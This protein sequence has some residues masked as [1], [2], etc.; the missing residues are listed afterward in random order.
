MWLEVVVEVAEESAGEEGEEAGGYVV[1]H[2]AGAGGEGFE[3]TDGPGFP[4]V[5]ETE[6]EEVER[7]VMPVGRGED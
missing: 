2:D 4:D 7:G 6:E 3:A 1:E 5:E